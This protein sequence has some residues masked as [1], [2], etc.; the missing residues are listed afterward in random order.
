MVKISKDVVARCVTPATCTATSRWVG[1]CSSTLPTTCF[2][3]GKQRNK[4]I[5]NI[6][7]SIS[8]PCLFLFVITITITRPLVSRVADLLSTTDITLIPTINP[9]GFDRASEGSC[10]GDII[11]RSYLRQD[12]FTDEFLARKYILFLPTMHME[13]MQETGRYNI[14]KRRNQ[15]LGCNKRQRYNHKKD[16]LSSQR[17]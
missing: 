16:S 10:I 5:D 6:K 1:K 15:G 8:S 14:Q 4:D 13:K 12:F 7:T 2:M 9:D 17:F 3:Q 11:S